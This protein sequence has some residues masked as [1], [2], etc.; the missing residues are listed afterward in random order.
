[1]LAD[2]VIGE[3]QPLECGPICRLDGGGFLERVN[4][5]GFASRGDQNVSQYVPGC[6]RV[7][8]AHG[9]GTCRLYSLVCS[10]ENLEHDAVEAERFGLIGIEL[11]RSSEVASSCV[12]IIFPVQRHNTERHVN[13][14]TFVIC[15]QCLEQELAPSREAF[16]AI[17]ES[18][19]G[20]DHVIVR[21]ADKS[22]GIIRL[23]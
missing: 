20:H 2:P 15:C 22:A 6:W 1:M 23:H 9:C 19:H 4:S 18:P 7:R 10:A 17:L 11:Q 21:H 14:S 13:V 3:L 8:S 16:L 5:F 12:K